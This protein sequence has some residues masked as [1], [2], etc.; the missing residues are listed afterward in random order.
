MRGATG[1]AI[2]ERRG[3][4]G[5]SS[6]AEQRGGTSPVTWMPAPARLPLGPSEGNRRPR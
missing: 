1:A 2:G 4:V 3:E 5:E 6:G